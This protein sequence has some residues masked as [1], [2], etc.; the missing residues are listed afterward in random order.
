MLHHTLWV[1]L[2]QGDSQFGEH[3]HVSPLKTQTSLEQRNQLIKVAIA[4]ILPHQIRKL[5]SMHNEVETTD[6]CK[7]ELLLGHTS[8]VDLLPDL[9]AVGLARALDG[10]LVVLKVYEGGGE[11][12][13]VGD[14]REED[15][16]S[17]VVAL[18]VSL[19]TRLLDVGDVGGA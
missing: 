6:L 7:A 9:D 1:V 18:G 3:A 19:V 16:G 4:L 10:T 17:L 15:F 5:I 11:L 12:S 14:G 2:A 8:L 13:P